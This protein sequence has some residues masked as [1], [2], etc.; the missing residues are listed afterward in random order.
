AD[1]GYDPEMG[2]RPLKRVIQQQIEDNLSDA[3]LSGE[4]NDGDNIIVDVV[5]GEIELQH[6][7][8][9]LSAEPEEE[10]VAAA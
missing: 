3:L 4:F 10:P 1:L 2:A 9:D 6:S 7:T 5:D 8:E